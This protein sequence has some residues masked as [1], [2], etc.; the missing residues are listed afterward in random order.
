MPRM[1]PRKCRQLVQ[2]LLFVVPGVALADQPNSDAFKTS[3]PL[4]LEIRYCGCAATDTGSSPSKLL[5]S[6]LQES[7]I[8]KVGVSAEDKG[9]VS[10]HELSMG[11][12][13][14]PA[15]D[16]PGKFWFSY[17]GVHKENGGTNTGNA[18][19]VLVEGQWVNIFDSSHQ[20]ENSS[21]YT[22]V[23]VRLVKSGS[24]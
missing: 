17:A 20:S 11:Y 1:I 6:F 13:L 3:K 16:S 8:L 5:P 7:R 14:R 21:Q 4:L 23:A 22:D 12:E 19:L 2:A 24:S 10:S 9:F 18:Q 15:K